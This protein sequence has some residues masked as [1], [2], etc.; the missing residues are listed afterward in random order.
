[1]SKEHTYTNGEVTIVWKKELCSHSKR[2]WTGLPGVFKPGE[3]PWIRPEGASTEAIVAQVAQ[4]PSGAL[5]IR[6]NGP[7]PEAQ[8]DLVRVELSANGPLLVKGTV[9]VQHADGRVETREG[10]CALCRCGSSANKPYCDGSH[11]KAGFIG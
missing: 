7:T 6:P 3:R 11:R 2:C 4:C 9:V 5:S 1:M 10:S 8:P